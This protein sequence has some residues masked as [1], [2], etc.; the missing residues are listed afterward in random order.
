M[1]TDSI[2]QALNEKNIPE[3]EKG[4]DRLIKSFKDYEAEVGTLKAKSLL[5]DAEIARA[6]QSIKMLTTTLG[7]VKEIVDAEA[8]ADEKIKLLKAS[9]KG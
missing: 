7:L 6:T 8:P 5:V 4:V 1:N 9:L 3:L 2:T